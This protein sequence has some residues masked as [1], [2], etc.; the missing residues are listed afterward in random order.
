MTVG[1]AGLTIAS[2]TGELAGAA[3][4]SPPGPASPYAHDP[5]ASINGLRTRAEALG[6]HIPSGRPE[7]TICKHWQ[8]IA[9]SG[10]MGTPYLFVTRNGNAGFCQITQD[11]DPSGDLSIV[12][13]AT[14][15]PYGERLR[16]N[17]LTKDTD[18]VDTAPP[19]ADRVVSHIS[20][21]GSPI[22]G[23]DDGD[24]WPHYMHPGG[25]QL[26]GDVLAIAMEDGVGAGNPDNGVIFVDV[27]D[28]LQP[29]LISR[30]DASLP[31]DPD[32]VDPSSWGA[33][34]AGV[35]QLADGR[36]LL[37]VTGKDNELLRFFVSNGTDLRDESLTWSHWR[38]VTEATI[39]TQIG[40]DWPS[41]DAF[42]DAHQSLNFIRT[43]PNDAT[44]VY[45]AGGRNTHP[46]LG[47]DHVD[48]YQVAVDIGGGTF[49][50]ARV[51]TRHLDTHATLT[52][53]T[54]GSG[55]IA[56]FKAASGFHVTPTGE[57]LVYA[58]EHD[59]TGPGGDTVSFGEWRFAKMTRDDSPTFDPT[60]FT[61]GPYTV[62]E[63]SSVQLFGTGDPPRTQAWVELYAD[64]DFGSRSAVIDYP[65]FHLDSWDDFD[66]LDGETTDPD[67]FSDDP[68]SV[69]W[70][71]PVGCTIRLND[72]DYR[73]DDF[74]GDVVVY[75]PSGQNPQQI[76]DLDDIGADS[77]ITSV[78]FLQ[79]D[80][81]AGEYVDGC[82]GYYDTPSTMAWDLDGNGSYET[83]GAGPSFSATTLDGPTTAQ[84]AVRAVHPTD[85]RTG[86]DVTEVIVENVSP[87]ITSSGLFGP[88]DVEIGVDVP[89]AIVGL[90]LT[91]EATF[92]DPGVV[93]THT[94]IIDWDDGIV[95]E[96]ADFES[97]SSATGGVT[98]H[99]TQTHVFA[100]SGTYDVE[101]HVIDDDGGTA[102][103]TLTVEVLSIEDAIGVIVDEIDDA[104][105]S[106]TSAPEI[107]TLARARDALIGS[108]GG[109]GQDGALDHL[110]NGN[111]VAAMVRLGEAVELLELAASNGADVDLALDLLGA[112]AGSIA[113]SAYADAVDAT[114][115][116]S[117]VQRA[118][119]AA[120]ESLL[121]EAAGHLAA[122][123]HQAGVDVYI[124]AV[125]RAAPLCHC[126]ER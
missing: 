101:V 97:F 123:D 45:L 95:D 3:E 14:R 89:A 35:T 62:G 7:P 16:S 49:S 46:V 10:G 119:L 17:R 115:P 13:L 76:A 55:N 66:Q 92:S 71:A 103:T 44:D 28:P 107:R 41:G 113:Q 63:G 108:S 32:R 104:I 59:N 52:D 15:D 42:G 33:G 34:L 11:D 57:V 58:T 19:T 60:A 99:L 54:L 51:A 24:T 64:P 40:V 112:V 61:N 70:F 81:A 18:I 53:G 91:L 74:P 22:V 96:S 26:V 65:D 72:D 38:D 68:S 109:L 56:S 116:P 6:W 102:Q 80:A 20:F 12:R 82:S 37:V 110:E 98:G 86:F 5:I 122:G 67:N 47:E 83:A 125:R 94:A 93:D 124:E 111:L 117:Q 43:G 105:A 100:A 126:T 88:G 77:S 31:T 9:R 23:D 30:M 50:M 90:P 78:S 29:K 2:A 84:I 36:Y 8:G 48:L 1:A 75:L 114:D 106:S 73:D 85:G 118:Q 25:V 21:D 4:A 121:I 69:R 87:A 120:I 27:A 39:E 79:W